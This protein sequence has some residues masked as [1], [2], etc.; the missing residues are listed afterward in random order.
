MKENLRLILE[1]EIEQLMR[2]DIPYFEIN[3]SSRDLNTEFGVIKNFFELSAVDNINRKINK[4]SV[5]DYE[6][7][8]ELIIESLK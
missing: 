6:Q 7:Q 1:H 4:L 5:K 3:S 2:G 8:R